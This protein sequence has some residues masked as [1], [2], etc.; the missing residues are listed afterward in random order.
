VTGQSVGPYRVLRKLGAGGMGEVYL[1]EDDRL[2]RRVALKSPSDA[3]LE[4]PDARVRLQREARAAARLNHANIAAV[5]DVLEWHGRPFIVMEHVEG[6]S[7]A[8][9]LPRGRIPLERALA[10]GIEL[11]QALEAAHAAGIVHRDLK[12]GN[13]MITPEGHVKVL[14]FG[15]AKLADVDSGTVSL[16]GPGAVLGTPGY[17]APEQLLGHRADARSDIYSTGAVLYQLLCGRAHWASYEERG[18]GLSAILAPVP[19]LATVDAGIPQDLSAVVARAMDREPRNRYGSASE[20]RRALERSA[21][22]LGEAT[23]VGAGTIRLP[24]KRHL[25]PVTL[26]VAILLLLIAAG[27]PFVW[28]WRTSAVPPSKSSA[29]PVIAVLPLQNISSDPKLE[30]VGAGF[31][32]TMST[33]LATV[34]GLAV[35]SR[36]EIH[37]ALNRKLDTAKLSRALGATY[38]VTG[39][40]QQAASQIHVTINLL[41][42]D[43]GRIINGAIYDDSFDNV[44]AL[45]RRI[46]EQLTKEIVGTLSATTQQRMAREPTNSVRALAE[47]WR[48]RDYLDKPGP[49]PIEPAIAAFEESVRID[50]SFALGH[51]GL[52]SAYWRKYGQTKDA[53]WAGRAT[54]ETEHAKRLDPAEPEVGYTLATVYSGSGRSDEAIAELQRVLELQPSSDAAH[55]KLGEI[56][57]VRRRIDDAVREFDEAIRLRPDYW[58]SHRAKGLLLWRAGRLSE[59]ETEFREVVRLQPDSPI[60]YQLL[61]NAHA[62]GGDFA[63]ATKDYQTAL[64]HGG[65]FGPNSSLGY[66]SYVQGRFDEAVTFYQRAIKARP[67][68]A[69][70]HWNLADALRHLGRDS[71]ARQEYQRAT[72]LFDVDLGID[73]T[74]GNSL[75]VRATCQAR[76]GRMAKAQADIARAVELAPDDA[77][78]Q[79]QRALVLSLAGRRDDALSA[80][81]KAVALGYSRALLR[82]DQDLGTLRSSARFQAL[83]GSE[84]PR[85]SR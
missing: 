39:G 13:V 32:E 45:Q 60:G 12:P 83:T 7:L 38:L 70:T 14:D 33:K 40:V 69:T 63:E 42:A 1:A 8:A 30:Y 61:G 57:G 68:S 11:T 2:G 49:D 31:A 77:D 67:G 46:A 24:P 59:A 52:G 4:T 5:Y 16:T 21:A 78:V 84:P 75:S 74:D 47:Y 26:A 15:L 25:S 62:S 19:P 3:W 48:G 71:E 73:A 76:L 37:D 51:A 29:L 54:E 34:N 65:N 43:G 44:F 50:P 64:N 36:S 23:T 53:T 72:E 20:L 28:R 41:S 79:Y 18:R 17:V 81:E 27:I 6:E 10:I 55:R 82:V 66:V 58:E 35:V 9:L 80:L 56:Y 22:A 85:R